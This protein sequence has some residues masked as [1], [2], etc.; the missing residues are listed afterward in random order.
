[1][2]KLNFILVLCN[3]IV[4]PI[5]ALHIINSLKTEI[6]SVSS[7]GAA[8]SNT[9]KHSNINKKS[10]RDFLLSTSAFISGI[11]ILSQHP[12]AVNAAC[13]TGDTSE[14]CIGV[15][16]VP[17]DEEI[18]PYIETPEQLER[19]APDL[20]WV[21]QPTYPKSY[22]DAIQEFNTMETTYLKDIKDNV[23]KGSLTVA[24]VQLLQMIP[25]F[26]VC[27]RVILK[28]LQARED[29][30]QDI[31]SLIEDR[32][33]ILYASIQN[34]DVMIGQ[35]LRGQMGV[36][37]VAQITILSELKQIEFDYNFFLKQ[38]VAL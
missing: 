28:T 15:Y 36:S 2:Q 31:Y 9:N 17:I 19:Y 26:T 20:N 1:M 37:A 12:N 24:G 25:R 7:A 6:M 23:L 10:R 4:S 11:N 38:V 35:G 30:N 3:I 32:Y 27:G 34:C 21:A 16:K 8:G 33:M 14:Q 18:L 22:N 29:I 13:L 5:E